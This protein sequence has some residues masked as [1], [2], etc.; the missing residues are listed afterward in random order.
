MKL[1]PTVALAAT[2]VAGS[3]CKRS[4][5]AAPA[6]A[7]AHADAE[8]ALPELTVQ[9]VADKLAR[10]ENVAVYDANNRGRYERGHVPGARW[11][12]FA[13]VQ[14]TDLPADHA[15]QLV[16]YCANEH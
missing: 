12:A 16:F 15:T 7:A 1:L 9:Q 3:A 4:Q 10:H 11:V 8:A 2:L 14:P 13:S 6:H 5:P